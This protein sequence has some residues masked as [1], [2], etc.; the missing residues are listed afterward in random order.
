LPAAVTQT[1]KRV[2]QPPVPL[3]PMTPVFR[4]ASLAAIELGR[5]VLLHGATGFKGRPGLGLRADALSA[6]GDLSEGV[7]RLGVAP[8]FERRALDETLIAIDIDYLLEADLR[9]AV[10]GPPASGDLLVAAQRPAA[11]GLY[12][13][14][15]WRG[16]AGL[17]DMASAIIRPYATSS[18]TA[19]VVLGWR[20][21]ERQHRG[22][23]IYEHGAR[24]QGASEPARDEPPRRAYGE[25]CD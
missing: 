8:R 16:A 3:V 19:P 1:A 22:R 10:P 17:L 21:V 5:L 25:E 13:A 6:Q 9:S 14:D 11:A 7:L 4:A 12:V 18:A 2:Y 20:L 23:L 24:E 15:L